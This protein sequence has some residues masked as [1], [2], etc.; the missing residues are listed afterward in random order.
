LDRA[1]VRRKA[2]R[3]HRDHGDHRAADGRNQAKRPLPGMA[4]SVSQPL[5]L[6]EST[7]ASWRCR[8]QCRG[9]RLCA[10]LDCDCDSDCDPDSDTDR[11]SVVRNDPFL[12]GKIFQVSSPKRS[13]AGIAAAPLRD[14]RGLC[15]EK[16]YDSVRNRRIL[17]LKSRRPFT[18]LYITPDF[19][20][21]TPAPPH[22]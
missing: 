5:S 2:K 18:T 16:A 19:S 3:N 22:S 14:L 21:L 20:L 9:T 13:R 17:V 11:Y 4:Q 7:S 12:V 6:S 15:G 8:H 1:A 10:V